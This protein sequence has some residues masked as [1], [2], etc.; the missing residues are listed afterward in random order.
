[1][2]RYECYNNYYVLCITFCQFKKPDMSYQC[3]LQIVNTQEG[4]ESGEE[5]LEYAEDG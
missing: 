5:A 2:L 1:M 4:L 3:S